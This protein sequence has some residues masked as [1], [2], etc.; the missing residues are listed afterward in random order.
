L[1]FNAEQRRYD[2]AVCDLRRL[3]SLRKAGLRRI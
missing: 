1:R 3:Q 2:R